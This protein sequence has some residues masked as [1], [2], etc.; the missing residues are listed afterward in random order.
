MRT[1]ETEGS[2]RPRRDGSG[3]QPASLARA[4]A[5]HLRRSRGAAGD[6]PD[7]RRRHRRDRRPHDPRR[8]P[9]AGR[10]RLLQLPR[11]RPRPRDHRRGPGD[12]ERWGT[13]PSWSRLLGSPRLYEEIEERLTDLL[14]A[15][16]HAGAADDHPHPHVGDP[17]AGGRRGRSSSTR[18]AHKTIY[19]GCQ[20]ARARGATV[21]RFRFE[22]PDHLDELL[23][24][25]RDPTRLVC[26]DGV[27]SMTGNAP[28]LRAFA[29]RRAASTTRCSTSTTPT[30]SA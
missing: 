19:D 25:E 17:G 20:V 12:L 2:A 1:T 23:R 10:L 8:R 4:L 11:L 26:M 30:A 13:H 15:R 29:A 24:A 28:D 7:D 5:R 21:E 3:T 6:A 22:D 18:R 16:G 9:L 27:N 14:G